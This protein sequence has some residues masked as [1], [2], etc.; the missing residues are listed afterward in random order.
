MSASSP[1]SPQGE[2][3]KGW[4]QEPGLSGA[5][6]E[7]CRAEEWQAEGEGPPG[8]L[9]LWGTDQLEEHGQMRGPSGP[10]CTLWCQLW[11]PDQPLSSRVTTWPA[12]LPS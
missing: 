1:A 12:W 6:G 10:Q 4:L 9:G 11:G 7:V 8:Q 5:A 2:E 3:R